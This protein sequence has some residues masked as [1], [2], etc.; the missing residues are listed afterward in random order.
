[1]N[2]SKSLKV[3]SLPMLFDDILANSDFDRSNKIIETMGQISKQNQIIYF[4]FNPV[5]VESFSKLG[6]QCEIIEL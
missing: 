2:N 4:T 5:V 3:E 6:S 1:M